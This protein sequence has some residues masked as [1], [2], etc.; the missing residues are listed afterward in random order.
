MFNNEPVVKK[1]NDNN[2]EKTNKQNAKHTLYYL[3]ISRVL[4]L[5]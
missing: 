2:A 4:I 3:Q 5:P 1:D